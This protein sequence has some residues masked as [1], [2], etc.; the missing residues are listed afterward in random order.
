MLQRNKSGGRC[1]GNDKKHTSASIRVP[2]TTRWRLLTLTLH[3]ASQRTPSRPIIS[4][5]NHHTFKG[6]QRS[7]SRR[8]SFSLYKSR[9]C[10]T[11]LR[12]DLVLADRVGMMAGAV[13]RWG[14]L[15]CKKR[16]AMRHRA[17]DVN[18]KCSAKV[19]VVS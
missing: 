17:N 10:H 1:I 12:K 13:L 6:H 8:A 7:N 5:H 9:V 3:F 2:H 15:C 18:E 11:D 4:L 19:G 14:S 16:V